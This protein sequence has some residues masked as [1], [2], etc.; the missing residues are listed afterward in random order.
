MRA[1]GYSSR[2]EECYVMWAR[3][4]ILFHNKRHPLEMAGREIEE[5]L[6]DLVVKGHVS[7]STQ[8]QA[9]NALL[10]LYQQVLEVELP[11]IRAVRSQR[12][13]RLPVVM[14]RAEVRE[15]LDAIEG[16]GGCMSTTAACSVR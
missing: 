9:L 4:C 12:P 6:T 13:R 3:R 15:L 10:F 2:T 16:Y 11:L 1:R 14:S 5:F 7:A 8:A